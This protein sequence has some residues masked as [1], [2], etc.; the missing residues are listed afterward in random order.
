MSDDNEIVVSTTEKDE[1]L[2]LPSVFRNYISL[3][4]AALAITSLVSIILLFLLELTSS[5]EKPYLGIL[6]YIMLPGVMLFGMAVILLGGLFERWKRRKMSPEEILA[7]PILDLNG[8]RRRRIF[9]VFLTATI[10]FIFISAFGSFR[11]YEFTE[12]V[13]FC[14]QT[15]H[16]VMNPEFTAYN[17]SPHARIRCVECHVGSGAESYVRAKMGGVR[18]LYKVIT[19]SYDKPIKT[20]VHNMRAA[21]E[22]CAKCHWSEK[23]H[24]DVIKV[25]NHYGYDEKSTLNQTRL[26]IKVGGGNPETGPVSGIHWHM[27]LG[28]DITFVSTDERRQDIAYIRMKD[29]NGNVVEYFDRESKVTQAEIDKAEKRRMDCID[30]HNRPTHVYLSPN[31]AIDKSLEAGRLDLSLPFIKSKTVEVLS[32]TYETNEQA[33]AAIA[34]GIDDFYKTSYP[35][36]YSAK[37]SSVDFAVTET[38][39]IY[40]TYFF[41]EMKTDWRAH[42]NNIGHLTVQGCFRCHDGQ[43]FSKEGKAIRNDCNICHTTIDQT[44]GGKTVTSPDGNFNHP[45]NLG[46]KGSWQCSSCHQ[47]NKAFQHPLNLGDITRFQC[48]ECHKDSKLLMPK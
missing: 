24:G 34:N 41:P 23:F 5:T 17:A 16:T 28:N 10:I 33:V 27:N 35:D 3:I 2:K 20:P 25:F 43:H 15:C 21:S 18:Q 39:R 13:T 42:P 1:K 37:K 14:G 6:I 12:S 47:G 29:M 32:G 31:Q 9:F 11:A 22:T 48:A 46:D 19:D 26:L 30:C 45:Q 7:Y 36:I 44:Y 4:G 8:P 40:Q 38:Q